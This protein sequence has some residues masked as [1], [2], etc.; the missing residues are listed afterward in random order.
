M[1]VAPD[2][3]P[4]H[5]AAPNLA[6]LPRF[7]EA[8]LTS[9]SRGVIPIVRIDDQIIGDGHPGPLTRTLSGRYDAWAEAHLEPI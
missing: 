9:S 1:A 4:V 6:D 5:E 2:V 7:Q 8:F 3:L